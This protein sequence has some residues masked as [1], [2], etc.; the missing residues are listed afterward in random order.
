MN[1]DGQVVK[2]AQGNHGRSHLES[3]SCKSPSGWPGADGQGLGPLLVHSLL[4]RP[5]F[6]ICLMAPGSY[7]S[8]CHRG[9]IPVNK[10]EESR[11]LPVLLALHWQN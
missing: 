1:L 3:P 8:S 2:E 7:A 11:S 5:L 10:K 4:Q 9:F 6:Q